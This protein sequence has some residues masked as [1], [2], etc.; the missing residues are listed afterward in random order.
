MGDVDGL[1]EARCSLGVTSNFSLDCAGPLGVM[2]VPPSFEDGE[3]ENSRLGRFAAG[4]CLPGVVEASEIVAHGSLR[5]MVTC[6]GFHADAS[7]VEGFN[8]E[9]RVAVEAPISGRGEGRSALLP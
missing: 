7:S 6:E 2:G 5:A 3:A 9:I 8:S 1:R 4:F